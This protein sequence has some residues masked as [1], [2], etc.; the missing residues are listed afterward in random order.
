MKFLVLKKHTL[1]FALILVV[2]CIFV[3]RPLGENSV[4]S[5]FFGDDLRKVPIYS[6][7]TPEKKVALSFDAAWGADKTQG[8]IDIL[9]Q[10]DVKATFFLVGFWVDDYPNEA[11]AIK[12]AGFEIGTHSTNH[13]DMVKLSKQEQKLELETSL[14]TIENCTGIKPKLFRAPFGSYNNTLLET[15]EELGLTT[16]QWSVDSLDWKGISASEICSRIL[17]KATNGSI[18]LCHNNS[19]NILTALPL[20]LSGLKNKGFEITC[21]GDLIYQNSFK[22]NRAGVQEKI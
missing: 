20:I 2:A 16:I 17:S 5:V 21:V 19:K 18:V 7:S 1:I 12:D 14:K 13:P 3:S 10:N 4:A 6:V 8:I 9:K 15:A 22:I 11:K